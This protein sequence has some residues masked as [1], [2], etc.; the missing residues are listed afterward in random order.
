MTLRFLGIQFFL[1]LRRFA[2]GID[3]LA[4]GAKEGYE[5]A[6]AV[7][8]HVA[9]TIDDGTALILREGTPDYDSAEWEERVAPRASALRVRDEVETR[10]KETALPS[11]VEVSVSRVSRF[12]ADDES[13]YRTAIVVVVSSPVTKDR[14]VVYPAE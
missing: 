11:C 8:Q 6:G 4:R 1:E 3:D 13:P 5:V 7:V 14:V 12:R 9:D 2:L 10:V